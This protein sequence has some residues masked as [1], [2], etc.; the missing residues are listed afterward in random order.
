MY[1]PKI[2]DL[3]GWL[4]YPKALWYMTSSN[5]YICIF[6]IIGEPGIGDLIQIKDNNH[7]ELYLISDIFRENE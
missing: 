7:P 1:Q 2:G 4:T 3:Y 6:N 5:H